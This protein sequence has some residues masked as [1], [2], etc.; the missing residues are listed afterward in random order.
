MKL[1]KV[2]V[3]IP[4]FNGWYFTKR[5]L[6]SVR[7]SSYCNYEI[8][9]VND[10]S[11]DETQL[12][13]KE[14]FPEAFVFNGDGNLW[15]S[16]SM[17]IGIDIAYNRGAEFV[18]VLNNDVEI[19]R[20][21]ISALIDVALNNERAIVGSVVRDISDP[22]KIWS[23]GGVMLWPRPGEVQLSSFLGSKNDFQYTE[24]NPGMGT[25]IPYS[26]FQ[27]VEGYDS[28]NFPQYLGDVDFCL[29]AIK[30]GFEI[31][32]TSK[33][34]IYNNIDNTGGMSIRGKYLS[35]KDIWDVFFSYRSPDYLKAR[36]VFI[37]RH[38]PAFYVI[39]AL[40]Y[41]YSRLSIYLL[42]LW[43]LGRKSV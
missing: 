6:N 13:L 26:I 19:E 36:L 34:I 18:L 35:T 23:S 33:S 1:P 29:R 22:Q 21:A 11:N 15:W 31:L 43:I 5:C 9:I 20:N 38:C 12:G 30:S 17:N 2:G 27:R 25:L 41:R 4:C 7:L 40:F 3:V 32:V 39:P 16:A 10:G 14:E 42:R 28:K 8:I 24:W 37:F